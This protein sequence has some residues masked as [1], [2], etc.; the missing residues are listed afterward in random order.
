MTHSIQP[1]LVLASSS[2]YRQAQ[3]ESLGLSFESRPADVDETPKPKELPMQL[4]MR[5]AK[6]KAEK[7][8]ALYPNS[9]VIGAD[10][11][12]AHQDTALG[13]PLTH[14]RARHQLKK[15]SGS[16]V[17]FY[18]AVS[19]RNSDQQVAFTVETEVEFRSLSDVEI[20]SYLQL[21]QPYDCAGAIKSEQRGSLLFR[22]VTSDDP[23]AL[24]GLPLIK[25]GEALRSFGINP[26][27]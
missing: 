5:L 23:T 18:S 7:V 20:E 10:Q 4:A 14:E 16:I 6:H 15:L 25:L 12:C 21:D 2:P 22:R 13:K 24:I 26:L 11:V 3:L 8:N 19:V 9:V 17:T 1:L 27:S